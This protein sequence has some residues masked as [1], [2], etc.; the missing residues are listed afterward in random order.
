M[1][2]QWIRKIGLFVF[3]DTEAIDLSAF[4]IV[5]EIHNA[6]VESPNHAVIRVFNLSSQTIQQLQIAE[7]A[8]VTLNAGYVGGNYG[9]VFSGT[10]KQFRIGRESATDTYLDI[11]AADGD[12]GYNQGFV[13]FSASKGSD[14]ATIAQNIANGMPGVT[15][16]PTAQQ[17]LSD[18][19]HPILPR[20]Q[21]LF[22]MAR[23]GLR[24]LAS[25]LDYSW[26][27]QD[28]KLTFI[29][30]AGYLPGEAVAI[31]TNTGMVG[32][33]QQT[34]Q[35]I[36]ITCLLNSRIRIGGLV[37]LNNKDIIQLLQQNPNNGPIP[38]NQ[39]AGIQ[40]NA[41]LAKD[42]I[43][44]AYVVEHEGDS[45]GNPWFTTITCLTTDL[46]AASS[47]SPTASVCTPDY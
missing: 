44:R 45:R 9:V 43:Y 37:Q 29:P 14:A 3:P 7:F 47:S 25:S 20:G 2:N 17:I 22:G 31:N 35:G 36:R 41:I 6:D 34:D 38:Y 24:G 42:G 23:A 21:V 10:I 28:G 11:L 40:Q 15:I 27:I 4:R 18:T 32:V 30:N 1:N 16:D 46:S 39:Y 26:S 5:F 33:P 8:S 13:N 12:I 19:Q